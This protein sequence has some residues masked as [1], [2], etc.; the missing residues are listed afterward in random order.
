M[1]TSEK[2]KISDEFLES[3]RPYVEALDRLTDAVPIGGTQLPEAASRAMEE[4]AGESTYAG[5]WGDTPIETAFGIVKFK[6]IAAVQAVQA[7]AGI[8]STGRGALYGPPMVA[9]GALENAARVRYL[10]DRNASFAQRVAR[11]LNERLYSA[12]EAL[13]EM[14]AQEAEIVEQEVPADRADQLELVREAIRRRRDLI[15]AI[16]T[17]ALS[18]ADDQPEFLWMKG[19]SNR[20]YLEADRPSSTALM[21]QLF[22]SPVLGPV[23]DAVGESLGRSAM[24][25]YSATLHGT[26]F[27]L[28]GALNTEAG[29]DLRGFYPLE[30]TTDD[31]RLLVRVVGTGLYAGLEEERLLNGWDWQGWQEAFIALMQLD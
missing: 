1:S 6:R 9:R 17:E 28:A 23:A 29:D 18:R 27:G 19:G 31:V 12:Y 21:K 22:A 20:F 24:A 30:L 5:R 3:V 8:Y 10:A 13:K 2:F 7:I 26:Q 25:A 14:N 11:G 4:I 16:E 15:D